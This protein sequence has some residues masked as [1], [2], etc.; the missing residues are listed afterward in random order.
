MSC[1]QKIVTAQ[2]LSGRVPDRAQT[3]SVWSNPIPSL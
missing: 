1:D 2:A 3:K